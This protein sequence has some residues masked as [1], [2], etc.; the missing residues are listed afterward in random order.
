MATDR[1]YSI[2]VFFCVLLIN[3]CARQAPALFS[4]SGLNTWRSIWKWVSIENCCGTHHLT[5]SFMLISL[6]SFIHRLDIRSSTQ[7]N[8]VQLQFQFPCTVNVSI[9]GMMW[10][11][12]QCNW[13]RWG[14]WRD[15]EMNLAGRQNELQYF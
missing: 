1:I 12:F 13:F 2:F 5:W 10:H 7:I 9:N 15:Y 4:L 3:A 14:L 8:N 11:S 6:M